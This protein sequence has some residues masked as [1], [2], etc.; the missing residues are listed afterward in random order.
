MKSEK[1]KF[2]VKD[3]KFLKILEEIKVLEESKPNKR[4]DDAISDASS[5]SQDEKDNLEKNKMN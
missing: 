2:A 3:L 1:K 4:K 5:D